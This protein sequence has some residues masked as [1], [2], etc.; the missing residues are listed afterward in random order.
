MEW[1]AKPFLQGHSGGWGHVA[2][3]TSLADLTFSF[4]GRS[5]T[6]LDNLSFSSPLRRRPA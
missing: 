1:S 6:E 3:N 4:R 2:S 5:S